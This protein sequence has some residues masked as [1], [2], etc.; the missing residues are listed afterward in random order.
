MKN[1][2][3]LCL[4][5]LSVFSL[6]SCETFPTIKPK[7][8]FGKE[9]SV[10]NSGATFS[11]QDMINASESTDFEKYKNKIN[12]VTIEKVTYTITEISG[13][14]KTLVGGTIAV[15]NSTGS[16]KTTLATLSNVNLAN[17]LNVET[18]LSTNADAIKIVEA[19]LLE[20]PNKLMIYY[21]GNADTGPIRLR[22]K[23]QFYSK[24]T[25]R[26]IGSN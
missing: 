24:V 18:D 4:S 22:V 13:N 9:F 12:K 11:G 19:A 26:L 3:L 21:S 8:V 20:E 16:N 1:L 6:T 25:A 14:A 17:A 10:N 5:V 15:A 23:L 7:I 2:V